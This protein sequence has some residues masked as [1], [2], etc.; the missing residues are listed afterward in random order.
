MDAEVTDPSADVDAAA[1]SD[2]KISAEAPS[3][4][5]DLDLPELKAADVN[6]PSVEGSS[7]ELDVN[8]SSPE[9][10]VKG[11]KGGF[12]MPK[13]GGFGSKSKWNISWQYNMAV[14]VKRF[15]LNDHHCGSCT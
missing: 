15:M 13:F 11:K 4:D 5:V 1:A 7:P 2:V 6:L 8:V 14:T 12:K 10:K 3:A 9:A